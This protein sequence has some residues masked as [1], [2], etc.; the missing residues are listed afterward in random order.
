[1]Q[2]GSK[3]DVDATVPSAEGALRSGDVAPRPTEWDVAKVLRST[4]YIKERIRSP[5]RKGVVALIR[6]SNFNNKT[7]R[8]VREL[9][10]AYN[11]DFQVCEIAGGNSAGQNN[12]IILGA[13]LEST[14]PRPH[15][16]VCVCDR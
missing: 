5:K 11:K 7:T 14:Q 15:H 4:V 1:M 9:G 2:W 13:D 6:E 8:C 3:S 16:A 10:G 12:A